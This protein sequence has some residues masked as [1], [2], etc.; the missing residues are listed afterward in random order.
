MVPANAHP[1]VLYARVSQTRDE[2][3][4]SVDDQ[5][6]ELRQWARQ[7]GWPIVGEYRDDDVSASRYAN[8]KARPGWDQAMDAVH[9]GQVKALLV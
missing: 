3:S 6:A 2:R 8:G 7:E 4:K 5:L 1:V 9:S